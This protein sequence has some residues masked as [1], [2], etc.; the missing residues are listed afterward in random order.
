MPDRCM[1]N[2]SLNNRRIQ[3]QLLTLAENFGLGIPSTRDLKEGI[4]WCGESNSDLATEQLFPSI[5]FGSKKEET[6][7]T[8]E[9]NSYVLSLRIT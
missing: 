3:L 5:A 2:F 4:V 1:Q 7:T 6:P 9:T 8:E